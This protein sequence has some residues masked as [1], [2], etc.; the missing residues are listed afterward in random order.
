LV[1]G[2]IVATV[3]CHRGF[4]ATGG[5]RGVGH[6]VTQASIFTNLYILFANFGLSHMLTLIDTLTE[7]LKGGSP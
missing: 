1:Y 3:S 2:T 6:A 5:A 4:I 7:G